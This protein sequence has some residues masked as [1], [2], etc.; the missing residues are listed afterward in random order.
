MRH[1]FSL[2][3]RPAAGA[4]PTVEEML[5]AARPAARGR[6][7]PVE[8]LESPDSYIV[9]FA[10]PGFSKEQLS[11]EVDGNALTVKAAKEPD[12]IPE[13]FRRIHSDGSASQA[14]RTI[15]LPA[16]VD[17][18]GASASARDGIAEAR[19]P[20]LAAPKRQVPIA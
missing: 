4:F 16:D 13:G 17:A 9:R 15:L 2:L 18:Q 1:Q 14:S 3:A 20:K 8:V 7:I 12:P 11:I 19:L 10:L 5:R 6:E